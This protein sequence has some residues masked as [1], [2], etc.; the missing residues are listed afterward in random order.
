LNRILSVIAGLIALFLMDE[1]GSVARGQTIQGGAGVMFLKRSDPDSNTLFVDNSYAAI[2]D[3]SD[4]DFAMNGGLLAEVRYLPNDV[5]YLEG[6]Y[7]GVND[8][9]SSSSYSSTSGAHLP[10]SGG[11]GVA[12]GGVDVTNTYTSELHSAELNALWNFCDRVRIGG[13]FRALELNE[14]LESEL[15]TASSVGEYENY[16]SN[17]LYGGQGVLDAT[18]FD[19][20][21]IFFVDGFLKLGAFG[22]HAKHTNYYDGGGATF[23]GESVDDIA[24]FVGEVGVNGNVQLTRHIQFRVGY[25]FLWLNGVGLSSDQIG[26]TVTGASPG[27]FADNDVSYNGLNLAIIAAR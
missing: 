21:G 18:L 2:G 6:R 14:E 13:G 23:S 25:N 10:G 17:R 16:V 4:L 5:W 1:V 15:E 11:A 8:F 3:A 9:E 20:G 12:N 26:N 24:T 27:V 19:N 22:N 7:F